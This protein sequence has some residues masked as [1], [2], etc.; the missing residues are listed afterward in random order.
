MLHCTTIAYSIV[1]DGSCSI[2]GSCINTTT[3]SNSTTGCCG[4]FL[5]STLT[6]LVPF[7]MTFCISTDRT[8]CGCNPRFSSD[9]DVACVGCLTTDVCLA[10]QTNSLSL[11]D[12]YCVSHASTAFIQ[13]LFMLSA[14]FIVTLTLLV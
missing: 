11:L 8:C 3:G 4:Q 6:G 13:Q 1:E 7:C 14:I 2:C 10:N 5:N 9:P 12:H